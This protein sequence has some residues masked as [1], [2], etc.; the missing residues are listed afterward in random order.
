[1]PNFENIDQYEARNPKSGQKEI[2]PIAPHSLQATD[3]R[4]RKRAG[5]QREAPEKTPPFPDVEV[6][7]VSV[8]QMEREFKMANRKLNRSSN[9]RGFKLVR[10]KLLNWLKR[11]FK[12][13]KGPPSQGKGSR[14]RNVRGGKD[15]ARGQ[16][17]PARPQQ[18]GNK[19]QEG[20]Q[21]SRRRRRRRSRGGP[22][23][24]SGGSQQQGKGATQQ[25]QSPSGPKDGQSQGMGKSRNRRNRRRG[26]RP[27]N[28]GNSNPGNAQ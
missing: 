5:A 19:P 14:N 17:K 27:G 24:P 25:Q 16:G 26:P 22:Q 23:D 18:G 1:M 9:R 4:P 10:F 12:R 3:Y 7:P 8:E 13:K 2:I 6:E 11:L 20:Q 21:S 15:R 28:G